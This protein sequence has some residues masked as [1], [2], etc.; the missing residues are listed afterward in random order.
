MVGMKVITKTVA[1]LAISVLMAVVMGVTSA[2]MRADNTRA[3]DNIE[4][5]QY[6]MRPLVDGHCNNEDPACPETLKDPVLLGDCP[7]DTTSTSEHYTL[8]PQKV[9][10]VQPKNQCQ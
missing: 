3:D 2:A 5:C 4:D 7:A 10:V 8:T 6:P 1:I 9:E